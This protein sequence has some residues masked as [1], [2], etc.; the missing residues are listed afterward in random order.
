MGA[1]HY[2][3]SGYATKYDVLCSDGRVIKK[4]AFD[5]SY[6]ETVPLVLYHDHKDPG[7]IVG[8]VLL[9]GRDDGLYAY[10]SLNESVNAE[11]TRIFL[12]HGD[13]DSLSIYAC[14]LVHDGNNVVKGRIGEVSL[15]MIGANPE[16]K[17][18]YL[19]LAHGADSSADAIIFSGEYLEDTEGG[20]VEEELKHEDESKEL[21]VGEV[22]KS[23][24]E[25]QKKVIGYLI[26]EAVKAATSGNNGDEAQHSYEEGED[27]MKTNMFEGENT[28]FSDELRHAAEGAILG[29]AK[30]IGS[31]QDSILAHS[32]E[33]GIDNISELFPD[34]K[35]L[36]TPPDWIKRDTE[37][38]AGVLSGCHKTPF[39]KVRTR[40]ADLREEAARALGYSKGNLKKEE[41]FGLLKREVG[42]TTIYKKQKL[43]RD[44][45]TDITDFNVVNWLW[46]EMNFM[47]KEEIA[48]AVLVGDG[49]DPVTQADD[50]INESCI[51]PIWKE[52][53]LFCV[54]KEVVV[55]SDMTE[56][57][58]A[59]ELIK[60]V[61]KSWK[62]Y[63][64]SGSPKF[65]TG[66]SFVTDAMLLEDGIGHFIYESKEK[67]ASKMRVSGIEEIEV[68]D[69]L[70]RTNDDSETMTLA[71]IMVNLRDY[72]IGTNAGGQ[73][74]KFEDFDIDYN[75]YKYLLETRLSGA[76]VKPFSAIVFEFVT[77]DPDD[78]EVV[79][80]D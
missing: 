60:A 42:P 35:D 23:F 6:G 19:N 40:F 76:L 65:Y 14:G 2:D 62:D 8:N 56:E 15:V 68:L 38:V 64:G 57:Q 61:M 25:D 54:K 63:H 3:F 52:A 34:Y 55:T 33:Y 67:I 79:I 11:K 43:D 21:T 5:S 71:G 24:T 20:S 49:R 45:I 48:R 37:W 16:A 17:I 28:G 74:A 39:A 51:I 22:M 1:K 7:M 30:E 18:D 50:K 77:R 13:L 53:D 44:D 27:D 36:N 78:V 59:K 31:L 72:N 29:D 75:Q 80:G 26:D 12:K 10:G 32:A 4:G 69:N 70:T 58:K 47:L 73:L 41:V 66:R 46:T 9:E